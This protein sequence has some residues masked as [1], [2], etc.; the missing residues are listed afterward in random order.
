[1]EFVYKREAAATAPAAFSVPS[2]AKTAQ[3]SSRAAALANTVFVLSALV[4]VLAVVFVVGGS[5]PNP[6]SMRPTFASPFMKAPFIG[7]KTFVGTTLR[8]SGG[9]RGSALVSFTDK[10]CPAC[11]DVTASFN[12]LELPG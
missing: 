7:P 8:T 4:V 11:H 5:K 3:S 6:L 12:A 9:F 2:C 1:M 10:S